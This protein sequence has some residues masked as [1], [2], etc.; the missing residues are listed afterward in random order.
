MTDA[1]WAAHEFQGL[2]FWERLVAQIVGAMKAPTEAEVKS[3]ARQV[4]D[5][6]LRR[7]RLDA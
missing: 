5:T 7:Y 6:F 4:V 3:H 1:Q 2:L